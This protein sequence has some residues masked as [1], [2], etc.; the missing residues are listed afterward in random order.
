[1]RDEVH[2]IYTADLLKGIAESLGATVRWKYSDLI[3]PEE[4]EPQ[5]S[6]D[7]IAMR[8]IEKLGLKGKSN[9]LHETEGD[10]VA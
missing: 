3:K 4:D 1:M 6:G 5:E 9:G 10:A 2:R 7:E 8:V